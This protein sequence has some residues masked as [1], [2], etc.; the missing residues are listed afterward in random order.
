MVDQAAA[1][2]QPQATRGAHSPTPPVGASSSLG[3]CSGL[4]TSEGLREKAADP[5]LGWLSSPVTVRGPQDLCHTYRPQTQVLA[6]PSESSQIKGP[7]RLKQT[8]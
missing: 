3:L 2:T 4:S 6:W 5:G 1:Q 7:V 8:S